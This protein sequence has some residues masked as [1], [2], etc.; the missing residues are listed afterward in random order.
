MAKEVRRRSDVTGKRRLLVCLDPREA[1][2]PSVRA[3]RVPG[4]DWD[5]DAGDES[6]M[7]S[8][9]D[10]NVERSYVQANDSITTRSPGILGD[11]NAWKDGVN[12]RVEEAPVAAKV[13]VGAA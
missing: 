2:G 10:I 1:V 12:G 11:S 13:P 4:W 8:G 7:R 3:E 6:P 9:G 5:A